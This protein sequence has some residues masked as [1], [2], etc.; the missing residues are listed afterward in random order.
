MIKKLFFFFVLFICSSNIF[1]LCSTCK[2]VV[3]NN[4]GEWGNGLNNGIFLL[5][6]PPYILLLIIVLVVFKG[7]IKKG[8]KNFVN[9]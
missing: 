9:S 7:K 3:E 4:D 2:A 1:A 6:I 8:F 5:M